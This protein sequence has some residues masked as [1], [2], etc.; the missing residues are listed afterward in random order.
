MKMHEKYLTNILDKI[1][2]LQE[3][4]PFKTMHNYKWTV[5]S[6]LLHTCCF[7]GLILEHPL[8]VSHN[9]INIKKHSSNSNWHL[10]VPGVPQLTSFTQCNAQTLLYHLTKFHNYWT[11]TNHKT[12]S[13][14]ANVGLAKNRHVMHNISSLCIKSS[15]TGLFSRVHNSDETQLTN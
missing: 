5:Q 1:K 9:I 14:R 13:P 7:L 3:I 12:T 2:Y 10:E 11:Y 8:Q 4:L 6:L 15:L